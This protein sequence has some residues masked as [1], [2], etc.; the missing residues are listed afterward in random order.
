MQKDVV[1]EPL[2]SFHGASRRSPARR[3]SA[4]IG[5]RLEVIID[6]VGPSMAEGGR[7][8]GDAPE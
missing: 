8:Q 6:Q 4:S 5:E 1:E 2:A 7:G 3:L